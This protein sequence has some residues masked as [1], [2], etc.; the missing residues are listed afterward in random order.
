MKKIISLVLAIV[1][2]ACCFVSCGETPEPVETELDLAEYRVIIP[3]KQN[4]TEKNFCNEFVDSLC[5]KIGKDLDYE[6]DF[7]NE[8]FGM[9]ETE[10]EILLGN[11]NREES[12]IEATETLNS[13]Q[14]KYVNKKIVI[15][16]EN[17]YAL[18]EA[19][20]KFLSDYVKNGST[21]IEIPSLK[22]QAKTAYYK[23]LEKIT[24]TAYGDSYFKYFAKQAEDNGNRWI[25]LLRDKYRMTLN[26]KG[27]G[28]STI[29]NVDGK[30]PMSSEERLSTLPAKTDI[31]LFE[32]GRNDS[33]AKVPVGKDLE[34]RDVDTY[35]GAVNYVLDHLQAKYPNAL[36]ICITPWYVGDGTEDYAQAMIDICELRGIA[37]FDATNQKV[38][39]VYMDKASFRAKY[40]WSSSDSSH[41][42]P[43]GMKLVF[44]AFEKFIGEE[45]TKFLS[46]K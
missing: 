22:D 7:I 24:L 27:Y 36:I 13:Y 42:N 33:V 38:T 44:P 37:C 10:R 9:V 35:A 25:D 5:Q 18:E 12:S 15:I 2:L 11:T 30:N 8:A 32:G 41:L 34:S 39:G 19:L 3:D 43:E 20:E 16:A 29:A 4:D 17:S 46:S 31:I 40:C 28:G 21:V 6:T 1:M 23:E 26:N 45:Y 14:I